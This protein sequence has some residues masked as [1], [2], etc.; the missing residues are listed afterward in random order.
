[1]IHARLVVV[2]VLVLVRALALSCTLIMFIAAS[3]GYTYD[4]DTVF[5]GRPDRRG[6]HFG[7]CTSLRIIR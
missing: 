1:M 5:T 7:T 6:F 2:L 4:M 3:R